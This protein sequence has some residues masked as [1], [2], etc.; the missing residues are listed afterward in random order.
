VAV[1]EVDRS[2]L[3]LW[4][5]A[6]SS[7][8]KIAYLGASE[9]PLSRSRSKLACGCDW[10]VNAAWFFGSGSSTK[11]G[12]QKEWVPAPQHPALK[13]WKYLCMH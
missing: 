10:H 1:L 5:C 6:T 3:L 13:V 7:R 8:L 11:T 4:V 9:V 2:E 12:L